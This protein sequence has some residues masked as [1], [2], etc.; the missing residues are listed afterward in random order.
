MFPKNFD[1]DH[2]S[3]GRRGIGRFHARPAAP[4]KLRSPEDFAGRNPLT[5]C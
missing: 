1:L 2:R 5:V 4:A 3:G